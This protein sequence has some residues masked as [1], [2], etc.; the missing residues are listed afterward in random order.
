MVELNTPTKITKSTPWKQVAYWSAR[1]SNA[2]PIS[3]VNV[4]I[5]P[6]NFQMTL[7]SHEFYHANHLLEGELSIV[8]EDKQYDL[9]PGDLF[10]LPP[11]IP[12]G[13]LS[14]TG[15]TQIGMDIDPQY[16]DKGFYKEFVNLC[17]G[18][19]VANFSI[20][21]SVVNLQ[22]NEMR[23]LLSAPT[24]YNNLR[25]LNIAE[26]KLLDLMEKLHSSSTSA[27]TLRFNEM[28]RSYQP[29]QL[30]LDDMCKYLLVSRSELERQ[31]HNSFGCGAS[32]YCA[33]LRFSKAC[34]M[35]QND[36]PLSTVAETLNFCDVGHFSKFFS[37]RAKMP[38]GQYRKTLQ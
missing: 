17:Q 19:K 26:S 20:P 33:R 15:Y 18:F 23:N 21:P 7:H 30:T 12:H 11:D 31:S 34:E 25:V 22:V 8:F 29:W 1:F 24:T 5:A 37:K 9:R 4:M 13:L 27:F 6:S 2:P 35:L 14:K 16:D 38:P 10:V 36:I 32:E 28:L 3:N